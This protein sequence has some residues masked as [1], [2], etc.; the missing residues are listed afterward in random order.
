MNPHFRFGRPPK[1]FDLS[2]AER[3]RLVREAV[4]QGRIV[5]CPPAI[6]EGAESPW[7]YLGAA[8]GYVRAEGA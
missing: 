8:Q 6:A 3:S 5:L 7:S 2:E 4:L 1:R